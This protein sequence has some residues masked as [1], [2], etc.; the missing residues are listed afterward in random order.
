MFQA[1][2]S[3]PGRIPYLCFFGF[4]YQ[5]TSSNSL[6]LRDM[7]L[8][9]IEVLVGHLSNIRTGGC[10]CVLKNMQLSMT[11][12]CPLHAATGLVC[13]CVKGSRIWT[14]LSSSPFLFVRHFSCL[15]TE[16]D[17]LSGFQE[18]R[19][20][21]LRLQHLQAFHPNFIILHH[22]FSSSVVSW[23]VMQASSFWA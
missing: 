3:S 16:W 23:H 5:V 14:Y 7:S 18:K 8:S 10:G 2:C 4:N 6:I 15:Q 1:L 9:T 12:S 11:L 20:W 17:I 13:R 21:L 22:H 19:K